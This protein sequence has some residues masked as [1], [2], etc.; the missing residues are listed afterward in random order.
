MWQRSTSDVA[1][2]TALQ[3]FI[4]FLVV[5]A[6]GFGG[7]LPMTHRM[8][9][10]DRRWLSEREFLDLFSICQ[11]LPG[12]N[13]VNLTILVGRRFQGIKGAVCAT[14]GVVA[15]PFVIVVFLAYAVGAVPNSGAV[16][17]ALKAMAAAATGMILA[18]GLRMGRAME[19]AWWQYLVALSVLLSV[20]FLRLPLLVVVFVAAPVTVYFAY[21]SRRE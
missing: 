14:V 8:L 7:V 5:G 12:P 17:A 3:L 10:Q 2:P 1:T 11:F 15:L 9:V 13:I 18:V 6:S 16:Q 4:A 19:G 20:A 21:R